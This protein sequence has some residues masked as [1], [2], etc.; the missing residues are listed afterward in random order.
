MICTNP[1]SMRNCSDEG[2]SDG[3]L[4]VCKEAIGQGCAGQRSEQRECSLKL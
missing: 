4:E 3:A 2:I 1:Y